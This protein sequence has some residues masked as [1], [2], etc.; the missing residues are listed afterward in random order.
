MDMY[1]FATTSP[2]YVT[3]GNQPVRSPSDAA[4]FVAWIDRLA[5]G[6]RAF[7]SWNAP[8]ERDHVLAQLDSARAVYVSRSNS[9]AP[10]RR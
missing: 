7:T 8:A 2:I 5:E 9:P 10:D 4:Y 6:V 3:V 1:P